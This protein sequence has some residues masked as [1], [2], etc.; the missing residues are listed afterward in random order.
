[1]LK[2]LFAAMTFIA[3]AL[4]PATAQTLLKTWAEWQAQNRPQMAAIEKLRSDSVQR[5]TQVCA[6]LADE[7]KKSDCIMRTETVIGR[8]T[9]E[10]NLLAGMIDAL[11]KLPQNEAIA[12]VVTVNP[13]YQESRTT[14]NGLTNSV[15]MDYPQKQASR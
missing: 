10:S 15:E 8:L 13:A 9:W 2:T 6:V 12:L 4:A 3:M 14:T 5:E 1:M 7:K 11:D